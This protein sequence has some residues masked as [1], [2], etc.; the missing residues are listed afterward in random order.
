[1]NFEDLTDLNIYNTQ[2][3]RRNS[4]YNMYHLLNKEKLTNMALNQ[5]KDM[6]N[7]I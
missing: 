5:N 2:G 7:Q 6:A 3:F 4:S 1:M